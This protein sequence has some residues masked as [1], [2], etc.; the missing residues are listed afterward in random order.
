MY[1]HVKLVGNKFKEPSY[2][3]KQAT[4]LINMIVIFTY[5]M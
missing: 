4:S 1:V 2:M 5:Y 3:Q